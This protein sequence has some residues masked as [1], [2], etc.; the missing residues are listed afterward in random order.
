MD[1]EVA[2]GGR[3]DGGTEFKSGAMVAQTAGLVGS[4]RRDRSSRGRAGYEADL[5]TV[6][7][8]DSTTGGRLE[9]DPVVEIPPVSDV[10]KYGGGEL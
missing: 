2:A 10:R 7:H 4:S 6:V 3:G 9:V 1:A 5:I 8:N